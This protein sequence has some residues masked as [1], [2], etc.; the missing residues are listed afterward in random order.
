MSNRDLYAMAAGLI[1]KPHLVT[2][3]EAVK[4]WS[5]EEI[6]HQKEVVTIKVVSQNHI[7]EPVTLQSRSIE[8]P[9]SPDQKVWL[10]FGF[11]GQQRHLV[12]VEIN[13][14]EITRFR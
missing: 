13:D 8:S 12:Q 14:I 10:N 3:A 11:S 9:D 1:P 7:Y 2:G 6:K 4:A 5:D